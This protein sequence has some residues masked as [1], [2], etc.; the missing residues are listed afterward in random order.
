MQ[1]TNN[2]N[3]IDL[4]RK[5][6]DKGTK[7]T[8]GN[9]DELQRKVEPNNNRKESKANDSGYLAQQTETPNDTATC[10]QYNE[11]RNDEI[12]RANGNCS[13]NQE[14]LMSPRK[15]PEKPQVVSKNFIKNEINSG[16]EKEK[17]K[18]EHIEEATRKVGELQDTNDDGKSSEKP[19]GIRTQKKKNWNKVKHAIK[20]T[21]RRK[22]S[23][24]VKILSKLGKLTENRE[25]GVDLEEPLTQKNLDDQSDKTNKTKGTAETPKQSIPDP[26]SDNHTIVDIKDD[27][28]K[29]QVNNLPSNQLCTEYTCTVI[30]V[31]F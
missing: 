24:G 21:S 8:G 16:G 30:A 9:N 17:E 12:D 6:G 13:D 5:R 28:E 1:L 4:G 27:S 20:A 2:T 25:A 7:S 18:T 23:D 19:T 15:R 22:N 14:D 31:P 3:K 10:R 26:K 29:K 11:S